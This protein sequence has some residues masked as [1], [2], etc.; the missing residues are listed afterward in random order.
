MAH[1]LLPP[2]R[3]SRGM[4]EA[5]RRALITGVTGQDGRYLS[6]LLLSL[7]YAVDGLVR[8]GDSVPG[9]LPAE[10]RILSGNLSDAGSL[11][12]ALSASRPAEVYNLAAATS[13]AESFEDP[14]AVADV[15]GLGPLRLLEAIRRADP[16]IR[17]L[18]ASSAE[19]FAGAATSPQNEETPICPVSPYGV[20]KASA[21]Q[22]VQVYRRSHRIFAATTI[23]YNHESPR[24]GPGFV[25]RKV[26]MAVARIALGMDTEVRL[27]NIDVERDWGYAPDYVRA[28]HLALQHEVADDFVV[29]T[30]ETHHL[31]ELLAI[32]FATADLDWRDHV[33][34]DPAL[35]RP[36]EPV[37][38][39]GDASR[40]RSRLGWAPSR[41]FAEI[42]REMV[43][44]DLDR[45]GREVASAPTPL[46]TSDVPQPQARR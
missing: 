4:P 5:G 24:R 7:G 31:R 33:V 22:L 8:P 30:G 44:A 34:T 45:L 26:T 12:A 38:L 25:T 3:Y 13:V 41:G 39:C 1:R 23:L 2:R 21:H 40:A 20:A 28:M 9:D 46:G 14:V 37:R 27:G 11:E 19:I 29:A 15:T 43:N 36:A 10:V 32:A 16:A 17:L 6:E 42:V 18:Q 35:F